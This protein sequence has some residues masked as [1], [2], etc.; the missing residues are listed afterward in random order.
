[1]VS[2]WFY[3]CPYSIFFREIH[4]PNCPDSAKADPCSSSAAGMPL[5]SLGAALNPRRNQGR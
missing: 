4:F 1:M 5:S 2:S 3:S